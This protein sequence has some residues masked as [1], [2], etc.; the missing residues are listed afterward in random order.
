MPISPKGR[1]LGARDAYSK[2]EPKR[3]CVPFSSPSSCRFAKGF[4]LD[5]LPLALFAVVTWIA[6]HR[7]HGIWHD[8][9]LYAGQAI[10]RLDPIPF[11]QDLFFAHGSQDS[12]TVFTVIYAA[13]IKKLGL[14]KASAI[15]LGT[16][17]LLWF[18]AVAWLLRSMFDGLSFWLALVL[19][20]TL[21]AT[22]G[23]FNIFAYGETFLTARVW[24]EALALAA[25]ACVLRGYRLAATVSVTLSAAMHPVIAFPATLLVYFL[26]FE[27]HQQSVLA[28]L[29]LFLLV[30]LSLAGIPPFANLSQTMDPLW[31]SLSVERSPFVF[32]DHWKVAD[33]REPVFFALLLITTALV[34]APGNRRLWWSVLAVLAIGMG[35][36]M[37][38]VYWRSVLLIQMQPWRVLWLTKVLTIAAGVRL[39]QATW[40]ISLFS[41]LLVGAL[42]VCTLTPDSVGLVY[43]LPLAALLVAECRYGLGLHLPRWCYRMIW[44]VIVVV[45]G[46]NLFWKIQFSSAFLDLTT[47]SVAGVTFVDHFFSASKDW[48]WF[49]FPCVLVAFWWL[50]R[51]H[52]ASGRWLVLLT[53]AS[54]VFFATNWQRTS[55]YQAAD[56]VLWETGFPE[57]TSI[58]RP[59]HLTYWGGGHVDLWFILHRGSYAS[60]QQAAGIIFSRQTAI[61]ANRRLS[62]LKQ[63]GL[64]DARFDWLPRKEEKSPPVSGSL[65]GLIHVCHDPILD[66]VVLPQRVTG[67]APIATVSLYRLGVKYNLYACAALRTMPDPISSSS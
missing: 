12:F 42:V 65:P 15:L 27:R 39:L 53:S 33:Y 5:W 52:A 4:P 45:I 57:L 16:A 37:L 43:A 1:E 35:L 63:L 67:T 9:V 6:T 32:L 46:E 31:L 50:L 11:E 18:A 22:Y 40:P 51:H 14:P 29:T 55:R 10:F 44:G 26:G 47:S 34:V 56:D 38:T 13:V 2:H 19:V 17:H 64:P 60:S 30:A 24:A 66:F 48:G 61:E 7:Y 23:S 25:L 3:T 59:H 36:A 41:R 58:I 21:P 28:T 62:R 54:L 20:G 49:V 8:G